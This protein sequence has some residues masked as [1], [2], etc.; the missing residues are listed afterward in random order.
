MIKTLDEAISYYNKKYNL[1]K[2]YDPL[3]AEEYKQLKQWLEEYK[4]LKEKEETEN[5]FNDILREVLNVY[6]TDNGLSDEALIDILNN[7][8]ISEKTQKE[9][10]AIISKKEGKYNRWN[11]I[12]K[13]MNDKE[14]INCQ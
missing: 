11:I 14:K 3:R 7:K 10:E 1:L 4:R 2:N 12:K 13:A 9:I 6:D 8:N 5:T